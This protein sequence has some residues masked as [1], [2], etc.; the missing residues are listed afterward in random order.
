VR[1]RQS[2]CSRWVYTPTTHFECGC[3]LSTHFYAGFQ[4]TRA[5]S[6]SELKCERGQVFLQY[7][8]IC[9]SESHI[10]KFAAQP[11]SPIRHS[12]ICIALERGELNFGLFGCW[13]L[14]NPASQLGT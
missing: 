2:M 1:Q 3:T 4:F 7:S 9:S 12:Q 11:F 5:Q 13:K 10:H 8:Q 14:Q 6:A